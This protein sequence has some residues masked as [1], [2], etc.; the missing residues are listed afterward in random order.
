MFVLATVQ[1]TSRKW[2][3]YRTTQNTHGEFGT[4][5]STSFIAHFIGM[6]SSFALR[7]MQWTRCTV[8]SIFLE[9]NVNNVRL[10][11]PWCPWCLYMCCHRYLVYSSGYTGKIRSNDNGK[12]YRSLIY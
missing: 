11:F 9:C 2:C 3:K 7:R 1:L 6:L 10:W 8:M 4:V 5:M 12:E